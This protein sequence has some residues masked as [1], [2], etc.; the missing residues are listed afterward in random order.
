MTE[1]AAQTN[2]QISLSGGS[3]ATE[4]DSVFLESLSVDISQQQTSA[5]YVKL[6]ATSSQ[7]TVGLRFS[8]T[9]GTLD[10]LDASGCFSTQISANSAGR[11]INTVSRL[12]NLI[13]EPTET[14][15]VTVSEDTDNP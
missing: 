7:P 1:A 2:A 10:T 13:D 3:S 8:S 5:I 9:F 4:D 6:C 11:S 12:E 14:V 15:T